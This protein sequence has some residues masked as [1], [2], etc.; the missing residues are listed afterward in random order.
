MSA[1]ATGSSYALQLGSFG[2]VSFFSFTHKLNY[3]LVLPLR[4]IC[5][6]EFVFCALALIK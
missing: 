5:N 6:Y 2:S 4:T 1:N 3:L